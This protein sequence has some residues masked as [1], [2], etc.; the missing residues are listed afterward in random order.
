MTRGRA[1]IQPDLLAD[2]PSAAD[3]HGRGHLGRG[4]AL[5]LLRGLRGPAD[6][7]RHGCFQKR[8]DPHDKAAVRPWPFEQRRQTHLSQAQ[9]SR[10]SN[11]HDNSG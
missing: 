9:H 10:S 3:C 11:E 8:V 4:Y 5:H 6:L 2:E 7:Y 1:V